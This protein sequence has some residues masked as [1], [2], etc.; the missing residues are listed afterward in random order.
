M[1][2]VNSIEIRNVTK[3]F[4]IKISE[5]DHK[6]KSSLKIRKNAKEKVVL[7]DV[8]FDIKRGEVVG[9]IGRNG[10]GKST[11]LKMISR[12]LEADSGTIEVNGTIASI[13]ELGMGFH[14]D[15]TGRENIYIKGSM[16]GFSRNEIDK[17]IDNII[18]YSNLGD[19]IDN[20]LKTYSSGMSGRLAF[21]IMI[22]VDADILLVDE[23]LSVGDVSFAAK[24]SQHFKSAAKSGKTVLFV[25]HSLA[26]IEEMCS[27]TI[28]ID[29]GK[30]RE[31]GPTKFVCDRYR[32]EMLESFDITSELAELGVPDAQYRLARMYLDENRMGVDP[33]IACEWMKR[34]AENR[35]LQA[36]VEY[37]D[38][39]FEGIGT[40]RDA[41]T[42]M[43]Y[44][45]M[46]ADRGNNDAKMK[47][48][49]MLGDEVDEDR[50]EM[51]MFFKKMAEDGHPSN[52][53]RYADLVLK[54]A[55]NEKDRKEAFEWFERA[56]ANGHL[57]SMCQ[58]AIMYRD[59]IGVSR[60]ANKAL[61][62]FTK[63]SENG[64]PKSQS[65][66][67]EL[68]LTGV[69]I[70]KDETE[71]FRWYLKAAQSGNPRS[72]YQVAIMYRDGIGTEVDTEKS[73]F[74]FKIFSNS[75]I[76]G[77]Q[78]VA[79]DILRNIETEGMSQEK[80]YL[81]AA[82]SFN[83]YGMY[84]L[85]ILHRDDVCKYDIDES[86]SRLSD[87]SNCGD[88]NS[89]LAL[90]DIYFKGLCVQRDLDKA[91]L[92]YRRAASNGNIQASYKV[93]MMYKEGLGTNMDYEAY[94][95]NL[96]FSSQFGNTDAIREMNKKQE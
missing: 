13:L 48:A 50:E 89:Q 28:W 42:A 95:T 86:I 17:R 47:V 73:K 31:N 24:A 83:A 94:L 72:Q 39:L 96:R 15:M 53:Y 82:K 49:L 6:Q 40:E 14:Q 55:W 12:I 26:T 44:Y 23:I 25:S 10:S 69:K 78:L 81:K 32:K 7:N 59:G 11:L 19:Y 41:V 62:Q 88:S 67:A 90:G 43:Q 46:A 36:G 66:L 21:A 54:T 33:L 37:A 4:K 61:E 84:K 76:V 22:H 58:T 57:E 2:D 56:A 65:I 30:V 71:A 27:R 93:A 35:H 85:G 77:H 80:M 51:R 29:D 18:Q 70:E 52:M 3:S 79:G 5:R 68:F 92:Q 63:A 64:H 8:S 87:S 34:A 75:A 20:P 91:F 9:I 38:M 74:W 16:Y 1:K 60:D 45:Q